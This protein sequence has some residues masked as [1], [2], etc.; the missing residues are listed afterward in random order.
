MSTR[1]PASLV[2]P[3]ARL[4]VALGLG[5]LAL[6]AFAVGA[7]CPVDNAAVDVTPQ[8]QNNVLRCIARGQATPTCPPTHPV[9]KIR[10][11][12]G[13][14]T[15]IDYCAPPNL[16]VPAPNQR[17]DVRCPPGMSR[18]TN[19]GPGNQDLCRSTSTNQV[20]PILIPN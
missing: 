10:P 16:L 13:E 3:A 11:G 4:V 19:A 12:E 5:A 17:A 2:R 20:P 9:Y 6:P 8:F 1:I 7:K 15:Q 14:S 18:V